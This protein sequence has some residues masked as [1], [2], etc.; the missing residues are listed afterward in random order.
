L[1]PPAK[2]GLSRTGHTPITKPTF[3][4]T[5]VLEDYDLAELAEYI[6]WTPFFH[7][8]E[9]K[10]PLPAHPHRRELGR[11]RHQALRRRPGHA[12][13]IIDG[14][15]LTA[16]A[17]LGFWPANTV[18]YDTIESLRRRQPRHGSHRVFHACASRA[19]R[20]ETSATWPSPISWRRKLGRADYM[21]GFA[22]T[23]GIGIEKLLDQF[24]AD[25]DDY[26]SIMVKPWPTAWPRPSPSACT[27]GCAASSGAT[28]P[29]STSPA[30]T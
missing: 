24:A 7:T 28:R 2:T 29:T 9:L 4:G 10:G 8:W 25:H 17:V 13:R 16:R 18:D 26:S 14:K 3:L 12:Q 27:S 6:D 1:K 21:G 23:A 15:L 30:T 5:K 19:K 22:V 20:P 11:S